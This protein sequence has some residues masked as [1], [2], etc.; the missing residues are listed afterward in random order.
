MK[1]H[2]RCYREEIIGDCEWI[3]TAGFFKSTLPHYYREVSVYWLKWGLSFRW[4]WRGEPND[5]TQGGQ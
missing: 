4:W 2:W 5:I 3:P 1:L